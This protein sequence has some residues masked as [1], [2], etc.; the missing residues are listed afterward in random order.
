[1]EL[2][3]TSSVEIEYWP[4]MDPTVVE[5]SREQRMDAYRMVRDELVRRIRTRFAAER[6]SD[7]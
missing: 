2:T 1:M 3:R 5:G 4:T 7:V 6:G